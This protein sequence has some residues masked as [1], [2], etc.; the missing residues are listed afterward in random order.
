[1]NFYGME[2]VE[3][4]LKYNMLLYHVYHVYQLH[5]QTLTGPFD[6]TLQT[7]NHITRASLQRN[8]GSA[9]SIYSIDEKMII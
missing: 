9:Y 2:A 4:E 1:M 5:L 6:Y 8:S 7:V 3:L